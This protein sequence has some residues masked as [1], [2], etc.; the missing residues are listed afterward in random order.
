VDLV[1]ALVSSFNVEGFQDYYEKPLTP[2]GIPSNKTDP[3][4]FLKPW[5]AKIPPGAPRRLFES[6]VKR[7]LVRPVSTSQLAFAYFGDLL[8]SGDREIRDDLTEMIGLPLRLLSQKLGALSSKGGGPSFLLCFVPSR[9]NDDPNLHL[10]GSLKHKDNPGVED[11]ELFWRDLCDHNG[12]NLLDLTEPFNSLETSFYPT[13]EAC[14]H[15]HYT[16][17]GNY[18]IATLL[19]YYLPSQK[20][21]SFHKTP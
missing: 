13:S 11:Y 8:A 7:G 9:D 14:C 17:Y 2:E 10:Y 6:C 21:I 15:R 19:S 5:G 3:E 1:L 18:L 4:F 12:L 16:A 20:W